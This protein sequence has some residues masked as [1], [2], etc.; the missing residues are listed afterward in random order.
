M[1]IRKRLYYFLIVI[2]LCCLIGYAHV[3]FF[4]LAQ[5]S[6]L[7]VLLLFVYEY[8]ILFVLNKESFEARRDCSDRFSNGDPNE[9][10]LHLHNHYPF[11]VNLE[12]I[13]EI[14]DI[15]QIRDQSFAVSMKSKENLTFTY[16]LR[17]VK[18]GVY[19]FGS[20]QVF[21]SSRTGFISRRIKQGE[22]SRIKTYPSFVYLKQY[23]LKAVSSRLTEHGSKRIRKSGHQL[24]PDQIKEY[25]K[26]EDY[27]FINWK[28]TARRNK[29]MSNLFQDERDQNLY[30]LIDKGRTM[31]SAFEGMTLLDYSINASLAL[32][33]V[34]LLKGDKAG[35]L[36]FEKEKD[37]FVPA[38]REPMQM[39]TLQESLYHQTTSFA[40]S[41][42]HNLYFAVNK[43]IKHRG[44]LLIFTNFDS[45]MSME[46]QLKYLSMLAKRHTVLVIFF[47]NAEVTE[48][49]KRKPQSKKETYETVVAQKLQREQAFIIQKLR[50]NNILS[51]LT[52]PD[53]LTA[54][55]I[56]KYLDI[57]RNQSI[58]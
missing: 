33:Y 1:F 6:L 37:T 10:K 8:L 5:I 47:E 40:E 34:S 58:F 22:P 38:S 24:E 17:P 32:S 13:D 15:F 55:V 19:I 4:R 30:C 3:V 11:P 35:L 27:R 46:R 23:E 26:G 12:I 16:C 49:A 21:I 20:I 41:D 18:R 42:Y 14:P 57:K 56:N 25:V 39:Q 29:L 36:T 48:L 43:Q 45:A 54:D 50:R 31:Q 9:V 53:Q 51:L 2:I 28:A 44:L 7:I 52:R